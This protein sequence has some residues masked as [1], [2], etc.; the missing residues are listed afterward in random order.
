VSTAIPLTFLVCLHWAT[1][2]YL[3]CNT[4][5]TKFPSQFKMTA[6]LKHASS[7]NK[8]CANV[9]LI[10]TLDKAYRPNNLSMITG[11]GQSLWM[12]WVL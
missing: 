3:I 11:L 9:T 10:A 1:F 5:I 7:K 6:V 8:G 2:T 4:C 12:G